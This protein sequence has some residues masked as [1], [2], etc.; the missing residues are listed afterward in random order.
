MAPSLPPPLPRPLPRH[1][2]AGQA[3]HPHD[4]RVLLLT[5]LPTAQRHASQL[6]W[7]ANGWN[8]PAGQRKQSIG[9]T[10]KQ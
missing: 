1:L 6:F 10:R 8:L 5:K 7:C 4:T 2:P 9:S 3:L